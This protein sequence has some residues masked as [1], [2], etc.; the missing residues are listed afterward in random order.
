MADVRKIDVTGTMVRANAGHGSY[1]QSKGLFPPNGSCSWLSGICGKWVGDRGNMDYMAIS[2]FSF[3]AYKVGQ[4][5]C[6]K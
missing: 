4:E 5:R 2:R 1:D 6:M 3:F